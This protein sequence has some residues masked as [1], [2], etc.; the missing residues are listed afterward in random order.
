MRRDVYHRVL[1]LDADPTAPGL[2]MVQR[3]G[4]WAGVGDLLRVLPPERPT[5]ILGNP[6][7]ADT[8]PTV[9]CPRCEAKSYEAM[10]ACKK[11]GGTGAYTPPP[12]PAAEAHV[13]RAL[14]VV[15][16]G[17]H[18]AFLLRLGMLEGAERLDLWREHPA[19]H[20]WV[21]ATRPPFTGEGADQTSYG[22]FLWRKGYKGTTTIET[23]DWRGSIPTSPNPRLLAHPEFA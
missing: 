21:L 12:T 7:Y 14:R 16:P 9:L 22:Y 1:A 13:R 4:G 3:D 15:Q 18:V 2:A 5:L 8:Q 23:T 10:A 11:C 6:P 20:I 17:G 19:L